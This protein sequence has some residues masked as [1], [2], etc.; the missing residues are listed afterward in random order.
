MGDMFVTYGYPFIDYN[1]G[2]SINGFITTLDKLLAMM[3]DNT[4]IMPGHGELST[5]ADMKNSGTDS[6]I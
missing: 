1:S 3:D 4:R 5:K 2:G 6:R